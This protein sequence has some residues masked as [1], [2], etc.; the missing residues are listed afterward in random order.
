[1]AVRAPVAEVDETAI[2]RSRYVA[3]LRGAAAVSADTVS[4]E[5]GHTGEEP[6]SS[7]AL[8]FD[9]EA[10]IAQQKRHQNR[11]TEY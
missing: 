1:M 6:A 5:Y 9:G 7:N 8:E 4:A 11:G 2:D 3:D 10:K